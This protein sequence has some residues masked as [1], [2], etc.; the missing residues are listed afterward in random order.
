MLCCIDTG[1]GDNPLEHVGELELIK[2]KCSILSP[3]AQF[4]ILI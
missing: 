2:P 3:L 1:S 4:N